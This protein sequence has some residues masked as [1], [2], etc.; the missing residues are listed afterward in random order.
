M[1]GALSFEVSDGTHFG[2]ILSQP[3]ATR[4]RPTVGLLACAY[5]E[6][7][8]MFRPEFK[9]DVTRD[10][11]RVAEHL[12]RDY[13]VVFPG[14]IDTLDS[15]DASGRAFSA[16][17]LDLLV[18]V[19]GT[20]VPDY[21]S[22][23]AIDHV[24]HVPVIM[25]TT[26]VGH[27]IH[28][29]DGYEVIMRNSGVIGTAQLSASFQKMGRPYD[30]VVG[31]IDDCQPYAEIRKHARVRSVVKRLR[32]L[33]VGVIGHV[34]RGMYD[35]ENDKTRIRSCLGPNIIYTE[36]S[37]LTEIW[38]KVTDDDANALADGLLTRFHARRIL[39]D[40]LLRSCRV[41]IAMERLA[42][43]LRFSSLCFLGQYV[44]EKEMGAPARLGASLMLEK[45]KI[46]VASEGDLAGLTMMHAMHWLSGG[47][48]LQAEW[49]H[50]DIARNLMMLVGHGVASPEIAESDAGVTLTAAPEAWGFAGSGVNLEFIMK[51]G[52]VTMGHLLDAADG[53]QMLISGAAAISSPCLPCDEI[54][55]LVELERPVQEYVAEMQRAG[56]PHHVIVVHGDI[57]EELKLLACQLAIKACVV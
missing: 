44:I 57:R 31:A 20:Y 37:H 23:Q 24:P 33:T 50:C 17:G 18:V 47:S 34:F 30:I 42:E 48:P 29:S 25:F 39:R 56:V 27:A 55:A 7:W 51:E 26:Q 46:M 10:L 4:E 22:L 21:I 28:S 3:P 6:Y 19:A 38:R 45:G 1:S 32:Q 16:A 14:L 13:E 5:F 12:R 9:Q 36:L 53:W 54:H 52:P 11:E 15:A 49:G 35:L 40:D 2:D 8:R 43:R 41:A